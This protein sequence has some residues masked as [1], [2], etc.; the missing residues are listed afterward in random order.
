MILPGIMHLHPRVPL[1]KA[2]AAAFAL[3]CG[4]VIGVLAAPLEWGGPSLTVGDIAP[5]DLVAQRSVQYVSE[6]L[7]E[8]ARENAAAAVEPVYLPRDE[9][10]GRAQAGALAALLDQVALIRQ[11]TDLPT[12]SE[13]LAA[14]DRVQEAAGLSTETKTALLALSTP[15][16]ESLRQRAAAALDAIM[17]QPIPPGGS[18]DAIESF[19]GQPQ[20]LPA[21]PAEQAVLRALLTKFVI[22]NVAIDEAATREKQ[23][24][25]R[26]NVP[27]QVVTFA[28]GQVVVPEGSAI[29]AA[30]LEALRQTGIIEDGFDVSKLIAASFVG[31]SFGI[32]AGGYLAAFGSVPAPGGRRLAVVAFS[33][34]AVLAMVRFGAP[35]LLPDDSHRYLVYALPV[36]A[37]GM[38]A[39]AF[40]GVEFGAL[41]SVLVGLTS[42]YLVVSEPAVPAANLRTSTEALQLAAAYAAGGLA[43]SLGVHR[44]ER[45]ARF[46]IAALVAGLGIGGVLGIFWLLY[47]SSSPSWLAWIGLAAGLGGTGSALL[48]L[49]V[50]VFLAQAFRV[51]TRLQLLEL[52]QANH[53]LLRRLRE[54]APGT[55]HHS[56]MVAALAE[57]AA[58]RIGADP[59]LA[60]AGAFFHDIGK[61]V[62]PGFFVENMLDGQPSPH[63]RLS[64]QESAE[65][66]R[67]HVTEGLILAR[68][69]GLPAVVRDFI[70]QHHGDR[71]VT[72]F[73]RQAVRQGGSADPAAF[74]YPGPKPQTKEAAVVMLADSCEAVVRA[75]PKRDPQSIDELVDSVVAER[76]A[77]GQ[78]DECD[79]TLRELQVVAESF[80]ASLRAIHHRRIE[81]PEPVPEEVAAILGPARREEPEPEPAAL[82]RIDFT[83]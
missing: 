66:I 36:G 61:L 47:D 56:M 78:L 31:A 63:E 62:H 48:T 4:V 12:Q 24:D 18:A 69:Y 39:T 35:P 22:P 21:S 41:I 45:L 65:I 50:Y 76:L 33:V 70:P 5:S 54:E 11:R 68:Q 7:T 6:V 10:V 23:Q 80:K 1:P 83:L 74:R 72:Y 53:P 73:Y 32:L 82:P 27:P 64:P 38:I 30:D 26:E 14:L 16:F 34:A 67:S 40:L 44:V 59:L 3:W 9:E 49:A 77:E 28:R 60:R 29:T 8:E 20:N 2:A 19:L 17:A 79:I 15:Q 25:A 52:A 58:E 13:K 51:T 43:G 55:F 71:L 42:A 75:A 37:A 46:S 57:R 81:Y